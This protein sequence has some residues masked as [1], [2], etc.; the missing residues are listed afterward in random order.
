MRL[1]ACAVG[2]ALLAVLLTGC[3]AGDYHRLPRPGG[4]EG[5]TANEVDYAF[6]S[7]KKGF[8]LPLAYTEFNPDVDD[9]VIFY[10]RVGQVRRPFTLRGVLSRPDGTQHASFTRSPDPNYKGPMWG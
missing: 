5:S 1:P 10:A 9:A 6:F 2:T 3:A 4:A 8:G 7:M